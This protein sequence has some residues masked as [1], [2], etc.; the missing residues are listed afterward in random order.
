MYARSLGALVTRREKPV[1]KTVRLTLATSASAS[2]PNFG[3]YL[4]NAGMPKAADI[5]RRG[6][7]SANPAGRGH[8]PP[9]GP[10]LMKVKASYRS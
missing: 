7:G 6:G 4:R 2:R 5:I 3:Y 9:L 1:K 8:D 10:S